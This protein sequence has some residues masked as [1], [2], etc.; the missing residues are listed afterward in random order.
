MSPHLSDQAND[1]LFIE[2]LRFFIELYCGNEMI[3]ACFKKNTCRFAG[4]QG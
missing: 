4:S 3:S 1:G 2:D